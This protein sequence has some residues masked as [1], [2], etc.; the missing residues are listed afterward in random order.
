MDC[1]GDSAKNLQHDVS[2]NYE[3]YKNAKVMFLKII[4]RVFSIFLRFSDEM[5][6][7]IRDEYYGDDYDVL[8]MQLQ[9]PY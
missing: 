3:T 7:I 4:T 2:K 9:M 8:C 6:N 1:W 5:V